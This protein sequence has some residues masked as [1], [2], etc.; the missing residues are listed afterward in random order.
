[1]LP[2]H[3]PPLRILRNMFDYDVETGFLKNKKSKKPA[4]PVSS[5]YCRVQI[6]KKIYPV[7]RIIWAL[8]NN[9]LPDPSYQIDHINGIRSDNRI[10]NLRLVT[11]S[12][13]NRN[14]IAQK[15]PRNGYPGLYFRKDRNMWR[16]SINI[17]GK[18]MWL[19][20]FKEKDEA[21]Q[22]RRNA[23]LE[24]DFYNIRVS[25]GDII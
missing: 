25:D 9:E 6:D 5:G 7:H 19:G 4:K 21:I 3:L 14:S 22:A 11:P 23:E 15:S 13:N 1:M 20:S 10:S 8:A 17:G 12:G 2:K 18:K 16:V 24:Y